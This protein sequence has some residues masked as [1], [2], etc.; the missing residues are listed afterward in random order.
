MLDA[1]GK[2]VAMPSHYFTVTAGAHDQVIKFETK[3]KAADWKATSK[4]KI[5]VN[6]VN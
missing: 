4:V 2:Q 5:V 3:L 1:S 6:W